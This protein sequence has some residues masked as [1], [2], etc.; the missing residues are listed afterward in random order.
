MTEEEKINIL[1]NIFK[2]M[3]VFTFTN[4]NGLYYVVNKRGYTETALYDKNL[5]FSIEP[6]FMKNDSFINEE[7]LS[8]ENINSDI[9][10]SGTEQIKCLEMFCRICKIKFLQLDDRSYV[11]W[12]NNKF[13]LQ[14]LSIMKYDMTFYNRLGYMQKDYLEDIEHWNDLKD[15]NFIQ[16]FDHIKENII[17]YDIIGRFLNVPGLTVGQCLE[18]V[19]KNNSFTGETFKSVGDF[20]YNVIR[21]NIDIEEDFIIHLFCLCA[22]CIECNECNDLFVKELVF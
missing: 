12:K 22:T 15:K 2:G 13:S 19:L 4:Q 17:S 10:I 1:K 7:S 20:L 6:D 21:N 9:G 14:H 5:I 11:M 16:Y 18:T 8:I 3:K